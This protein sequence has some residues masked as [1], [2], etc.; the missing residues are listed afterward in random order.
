MNGSP[1]RQMIFLAVAA[2]IVMLVFVFWRFIPQGGS[3]SSSAAPEPASSSAA[4]ESASPEP[5]NSENKQ[6]E[7]TFH[8]YACSPD[9]SQQVQG[10]DD[11]RNGN[12]A[13]RDDCPKAPQVSESYAEGCWAYADEKSGGGSP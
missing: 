5:E 7:Q 11:A 1:Q 9:C 10:Y 13:S 2:V 4:A 6:D 8:G 3:A 12:V